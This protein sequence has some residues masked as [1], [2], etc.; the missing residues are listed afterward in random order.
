MLA[1]MTELITFGET[2]LRV[3]P[4][5][6]RRLETARE[7]ELHADGTESTVAIAAG[8][9]GAECT[10]ISKLPETPPGRR[11]VRELEQHGIATEVGW[12]G[13]GEARVGVVYH[14][15]APEPRAAGTWHDRDLTTAAT[16]TPGDVPMASG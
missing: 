6:A 3:S 13:D 5:D 7:A 15:D 9:L 12:A 1:R 2:P 16:V 4:P 10:W 14:E 11:I 8:C